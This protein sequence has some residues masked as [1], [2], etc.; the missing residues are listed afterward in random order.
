MKSKAFIM[1]TM[2]KLLSRRPPTPS[3]GRGNSSSSKSSS[4]AK[5]I[6]RSWRLVQHQTNQQLHAKC[7]LVKAREGEGWREV[8]RGE[9]EEAEEGAAR[10]RSVKIGKAAF[11]ARVKNCSTVRCTAR[12][13]APTGSGGDGDGD[14]DVDAA[15]AGLCRSHAG[16]AW[17]GLA[18]P[19]TTLLTQIA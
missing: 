3:R 7:T 9:G 16:R 15:G 5:N 6:L 1:A 8:A 11:C 4:A 18:W 17:P 2:L 12:K 13:C 10:Q 14:G 19:T